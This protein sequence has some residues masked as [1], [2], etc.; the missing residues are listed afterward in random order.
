ML[1]LCQA[2]EESIHHHLRD[3]APGGAGPT[4]AIVP[5]TCARPST[6]TSG[7]VRVVLQQPAVGNIQLI[8]EQLLQGIDRR[9]NFGRRGRGGSGL[10]PV[11]LGALRCEA[12]SVLNVD[13]CHR[14][15]GDSA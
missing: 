5:P 13:G 7:P 11:A 10:A 4:R 12:D 15:F 6:V 14:L 9:R 3:T 8:L 1:P 2:G